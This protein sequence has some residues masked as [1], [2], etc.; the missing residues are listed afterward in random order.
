MVEC[1]QRLVRTLGEKVNLLL[2]S[3]LGKETSALG[4]G[5]SAP[6][7]VQLPCTKTVAKQLQSAEKRKKIL[8]GNEITD[9][10]DTKWGVRLSGRRRH[11]RIG[12]ELRNIN[13]VVKDLHRTKPRRAA[14]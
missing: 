4:Q 14:I 12:V 3:V 6:D 5:L 9:G 8:C 2:Q 10:A 11:S 7:N 1:R 13:A